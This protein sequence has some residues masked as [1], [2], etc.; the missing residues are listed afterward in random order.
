VNIK[1]PSKDSKDHNKKCF[2]NDAIINSSHLAENEAGPEL[3]M[4]TNPHPLLLLKAI[5]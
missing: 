5:P 2:W 4:P 3:S 1:D